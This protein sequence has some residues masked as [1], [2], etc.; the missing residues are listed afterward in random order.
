MLVGTT[1]R[2]SMVFFPAMPTFAVTCAPRPTRQR[3]RLHASGNVE[4]PQPRMLENERVVDG[5]IDGQLVSP[6]RV[7]MCSEFRARRR[8]LDSAEW[9]ATAAVVDDPRDHRLVRFRR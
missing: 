3:N 4:E 5:T 1:S 8:H 2:S 6:A 7:G 9:P